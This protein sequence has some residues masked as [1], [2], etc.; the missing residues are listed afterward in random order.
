MV[1]LQ[2]LQSYKKRDGDR[3]SIGNVDAP[4]ARIKRVGKRGLGAKATGGYPPI[5]IAYRI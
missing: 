4:M 1:F 2:F 5:S 3:Q